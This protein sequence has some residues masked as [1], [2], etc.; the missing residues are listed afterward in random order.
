[1]VTGRPVA[2]DNDRLGV[3][4]AVRSREVCGVVS[5]ES[6]LLGQVARLLGQEVANVEQFEFF[7]PCAEVV[8]RRTKLRRPHPSS[9]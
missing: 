1:M 3:V 7:A 6:M 5:L 2:G 9:R 4:D 8:H